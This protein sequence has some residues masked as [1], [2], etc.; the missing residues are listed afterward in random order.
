MSNNLIMELSEAMEIFLH[1]IAI[2]T[3]AETQIICDSFPIQWFVNAKPWNDRG[4]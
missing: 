3:I 1:Q 4:F 2:V